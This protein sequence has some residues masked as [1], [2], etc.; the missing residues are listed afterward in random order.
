MILFEN[1]N[2]VKALKKEYTDLLSLATRQLNF[3]LNHIVYKQIY[4]FA[5]GIALG[6]LPANAF[7]AYY[8]INWFDSCPLEY[9]SVC[10]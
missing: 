6:P 1:N 3:L 7:L 2:I 10:Y 4:G 5:M 9:R 8:K